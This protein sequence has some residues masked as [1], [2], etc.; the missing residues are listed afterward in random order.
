VLERLSDEKAAVER[1]A[2]AKRVAGEKAAVEWRA[3]AKRVADEIVKAKQLAINQLIEEDERKS[4]SD[5]LVDEARNYRWFCMM[6]CE[7][8]AEW[9]AI[10]DALDSTHAADA[11][12]E[13]EIDGGVL[14]EMDDDELEKVG[15]KYGVRKRIRKHINILEKQRDGEY[16]DESD[17]DDDL[18]PAYYE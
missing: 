14:F 18:P 13:N 12:R 5:N 7:K 11:V 10:A 6:R 15:F 2:E 16:N 17:S 1:R 9:C 3:E 4:N 8:L